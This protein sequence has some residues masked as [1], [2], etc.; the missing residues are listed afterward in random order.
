M[1]AESARII[2]LLK[3]FAISIGRAKEIEEYCD[4]GSR[5]EENLVVASSDEE[6]VKFP[7]QPAITEIS[8]EDG[9]KLE[10]FLDV[11]TED[12]ADITG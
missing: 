5:P 9:S 3:K 2:D 1:R 8:R 12:E 10:E 11:L 6:I 7:T 4:D